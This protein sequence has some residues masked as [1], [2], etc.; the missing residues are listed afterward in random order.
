M[1]SL[2]QHH[3]IIIDFL[4]DVDEEASGAFGFTP[5][6]SEEWKFLNEIIKS[7]INRI[8]LSEVP[9][10]SGYESYKLTR[11]VDRINELLYSFS[12]TA[13]FKASIN[14]FISMPWALAPCSIDSNRAN[15]QPT[16]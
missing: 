2:E 9:G 14:L 7:G 15:A 5:T 6:K 16:Q 4:R 13:L 3:K 11:L 12:S 8:K 1:S 10:F